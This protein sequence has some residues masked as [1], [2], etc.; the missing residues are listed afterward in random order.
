MAR[1]PREHRSA[2]EKLEI[3][4]YARQT[5][6]RQAAV[7]FGI[8]SAG[9]ISR[10]KNQENQLKQ[11]AA[12]GNMTVHY[13]KST[14][15]PEMDEIVVQWILDKRSRDVQ[16]STNDMIAKCCSLERGFRALSDTA[17]VAYCDRILKKHNLSIRRVTHVGQ[18]LYTEIQ[19]EA[20]DFQLSF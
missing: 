16:V 2:R 12:K 9:T 4:Q 3:V 15:Y 18:K 10:W 6:L 14:K 13:G 1:G 7:R 19:D 8:K 5:S 11:A 17:Q 20:K